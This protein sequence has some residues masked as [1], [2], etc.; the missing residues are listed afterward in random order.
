MSVFPGHLSN[1]NGFSTEGVSVYVHCLFEKCNPSSWE[2]EARSAKELEASLDY[3]IRLS[4]KKQS[5]NVVFVMAD[6][7]SKVPFRNVRF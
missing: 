5:K 3:A 6:K 7:H 1:L 4:L 2:T